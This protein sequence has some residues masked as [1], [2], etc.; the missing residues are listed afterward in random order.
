MVI[1]NVKKYVEDYIG[2]EVKRAVITVPAYF[3]ESQKKSY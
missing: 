1:G 2:E 3:N